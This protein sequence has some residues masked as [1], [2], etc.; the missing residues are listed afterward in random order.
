MK[1]MITAAVQ[2]VVEVEDDPEVEYYPD[3]DKYIQARDTIMQGIEDH[4][5]SNEV[6]VLGMDITSED[7]WEDE[8]VCP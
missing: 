6:H 2:F 8:N 7:D 5:R 4:L 3:D 1:M